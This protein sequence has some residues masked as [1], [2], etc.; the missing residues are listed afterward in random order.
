MNVANISLLA[1]IIL[2]LRHG[3]ILSCT[4]TALLSRALR[5]L[6]ITGAGANGSDWGTTVILDSVS[7]SIFPWPGDATLANSFLTHPQPVLLSAVLEATLLNLMLTLRLH[8]HPVW[9]LYKSNHFNLLKVCARTIFENW[10]IKMLNI[11][12]LCE[13]L[14]RTQMTPKRLIC[15]TSFVHLCFIISEVPTV[16][17]SDVS[18]LMLLTVELMKPNVCFAVQTMFKQM[19]LHFESSGHWWVSILCTNFIFPAQTNQTGDG[20]THVQRKRFH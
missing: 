3:P 19:S 4:S 6:G 7:L 11:W 17:L 10:N 13:H 12:Q 1:N 2:P 18:C 20:Y 5:A 9:P 8:E 16:Q 14:I 15:L